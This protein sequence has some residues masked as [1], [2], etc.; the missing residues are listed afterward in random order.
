[1]ESTQIQN[2]EDN[3]QAPYGGIGPL[4]SRRAMPEL[5]ADPSDGWLTRKFSGFLAAL[6]YYPPR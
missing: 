6:F 4:L 3:Q 2:A 5:A 1:M